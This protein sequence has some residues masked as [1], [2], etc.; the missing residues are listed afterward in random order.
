MGVACRHIGC[1]RQPVVGRSDD[2]RSI[3]GTCPGQSCQIGSCRIEDIFGEVDASA[4]IWAYDVSARRVCAAPHPPSDSL[5]AI[6]DGLERTV[7]D[8]RFVCAIG[9]GRVATHAHHHEVEYRSGRLDSRK[10]AATDSNLAVC[11]EWGIEGETRVAEVSQR[12]HAVV[13]LGNDGKRHVGAII[14]H[15]HGSITLLDDAF[16][17]HII[18][19]CGLGLGGE[20]AEHAVEHNCPVVGYGAG[21]GGCGTIHIDSAV[22]YLEC[23]KGNVAHAIDSSNRVPVGDAQFPRV[24]ASLDDRVGQHKVGYHQ[25]VAI[26]ANAHLAAAIAHCSHQR[27]VGSH[28]RIKG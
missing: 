3:L 8:N 4:H 26:C 5:V 28:I 22:L 19:G 6:G 17:A 21:D 18:I 9:F 15:R 12:H 1:Y 23:D 10:L 27:L 25:R 7:I 2:I 11:G 14:I 13:L 20:K 24:H 16:S